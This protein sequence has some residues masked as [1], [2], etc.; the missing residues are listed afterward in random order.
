MKG[1]Q[2]GNTLPHLFKHYNTKKAVTF[3]TA[4]FKYREAR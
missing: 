2:T 3:V 1:I 4:F